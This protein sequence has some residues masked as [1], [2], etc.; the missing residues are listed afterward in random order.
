MLELN[1]F[2]ERIAKASTLLSQVGDEEVQL[3]PTAREKVAQIGQRVLY[4]IKH[5]GPE[6]VATPVLVIYAMV[7]R[8]T[9][10]DLQSDRSFVR[11]LVEGAAGS[12]CSTG[13]TRR[14]PD[15]YDDFDD[16]VNVYMNG[17]V[18]KICERDGVDQVNLLG[19][20][21]AACFRC[22]IRR[23]TPNGSRTSSLSSRPSTF[24]RTRR[25][26]GRI[27]AS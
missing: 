3:A 18:E 11:N 1:Q 4:E 19:I 6:R 21:R 12:T 22:S 7:G 16:L 15:R 10:L 23:C 5:E 26:G 27:R 9:I 17:F 8:W 24:M 20:C 2:S 25:R 13:D 14:P